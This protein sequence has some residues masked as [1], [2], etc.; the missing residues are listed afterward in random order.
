MP[1]LALL[2]V[3]VAALLHAWWNVVVKQAKGDAHF[4]LLVGLTIVVLWA[5]AG[6]WAAAGELSGWGWR[7][8]LAVLASGVVHLVYFST[9]LRGY[10]ESDL[11]VVYPVARGTGPLLSS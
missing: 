1:G 4:Q 7:Q 11:T 2:L 9:L 10:R 5:P 8:M 6:L 3:F